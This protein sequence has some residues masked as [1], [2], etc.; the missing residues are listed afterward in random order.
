MIGVRDRKGGI[1]SLDGVQSDEPQTRIPR[2]WRSR[3]RLHLTA[4][5]TP[6]MLLLWIFVIYVFV[7]LAYTVIAERIHSAADPYA[8]QEPHLFWLVLVILISVLMVLLM[9]SSVLSFTVVDR[10]GVRAYRFLVC[11]WRRRDFSWEDF[12]WGSYVLMANTVSNGMLVNSGNLCVSRN[13]GNWQPE[14]ES[15]EEF[16]SYDRP[17][18]ALV[19][20]DGTRI[21]GLQVFSFFGGNAGERVDRRW[22]QVIKWAEYKGYLRQGDT[23]PGVA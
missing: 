18:R 9:I 5:R 3:D 12:R 10:G 11:Y 21:P 8:T 2:R 19:K 4:L 17:R 20:G 6:V 14:D 23:R 15:T 7:Y 13:W 16:A 22:L 1:M